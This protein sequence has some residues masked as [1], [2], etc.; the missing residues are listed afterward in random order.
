MVLYKNWLKAEEG[1]KR[2]IEVPE[3]LMLNGFVQ[4]LTKDW[5]RRKAT[6]RPAPPQV[7]ILF[8]LWTSSWPDNT[9]SVTWFLSDVGWFAHRWEHGLHRISPSE[10]S[11]LNRHPSSQENPLHNLCQ[12]FQRRCWQGFHLVVRWG[13]HS[14]QLGMRQDTMVRWGFLLV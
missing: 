13:K 3:K 12:I 5:R 11:P 14:Q 10:E 2:L 4:K 9:S 7:K 1:E 8:N 6:N